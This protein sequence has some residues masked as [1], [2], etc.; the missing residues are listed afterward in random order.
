MPW[1]TPGLSWMRVA[2]FAALALCAVLVGVVACGGGGGHAPRQVGRLLETA[3]EEGHRY[4][5]IDQQDAP[6]VGVE[7][8]TD[9]GKGWDVRLA[10][11][12]FS[13]SPARTAPGSAVAGHGYAQLYLDGRPVARLRADG[14]RLPLTRVTRGTHHVTARLYA[15]DRTVWAVEGRPVEATAD[16]TASGADTTPDATGTGSK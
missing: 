9:T 10:L 14:Y 13:F 6:E 1:T 5:Q 2:L 15:D 4:R 11:R 16:L 12:R 3:D 8:T 7:V